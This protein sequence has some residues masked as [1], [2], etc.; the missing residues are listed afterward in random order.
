VKDPIIYRSW[1]RDTISEAISEFNHHMHDGAGI[2]EIEAG[3]H[4][5]DFL[6]RASELG[7]DLEARLDGAVTEGRMRI[8]LMLEQLDQQEKVQRAI[9]ALKHLQVTIRGIQRRIECPPDAE[10]YLAQRR[11]GAVL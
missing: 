1:P 5:L 7:S 3:L 11:M 6:T 10:E 8:T 2:E 4:G 9:T